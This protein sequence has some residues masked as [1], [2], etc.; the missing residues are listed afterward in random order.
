LRAI[1]RN[2]FRNVATR[3]FSQIKK[4]DS[5]IAAPARAAMKL[6]LK[7]MR[8]VRRPQIAATA[9]TVSAKPLDARSHELRLRVE[10]RRPLS[11]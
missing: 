10:V 8:E 2:D 3:A 1:E 4:S 9:N 7:M 5:A 6:D 11:E